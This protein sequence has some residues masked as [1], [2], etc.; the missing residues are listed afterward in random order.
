[1]P[2]VS[3]SNY[4]GRSAQITNTVINERKRNL[5][6]LTHVP[7]PRWH[8]AVIISIAL[9]TTAWLFSYTL[10]DWSWQQS[11]GGW[12]WIYFAT[13]VVVFS[14]ALRRW[15]NDPRRQFG[16]ETADLDEDPHGSI[17]AQVNA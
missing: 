2:S 12:N 4:V 8:G 3:S 5:G 7:S 13:G 14:I 11:R 15:H 17:R 10:L 16:A 9:V 1:M 6:G